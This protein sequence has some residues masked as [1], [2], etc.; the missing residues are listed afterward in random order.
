MRRLRLVDQSMCSIPPKT[1][2]VPDQTD[3]SN[4]ARLFGSN[5][6]YKPLQQNSYWARCRIYDITNINK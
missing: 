1:R 5:Y 2:S 6:L 4:I 3:K